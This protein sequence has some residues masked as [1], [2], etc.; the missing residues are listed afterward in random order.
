MEQLLSSLLSISE[1]SKL[2]WPSTMRN[3]N[4][5]AA[6]QGVEK[7]A[8]EIGKELEKQFSAFDAKTIS[9]EQGPGDPDIVNFKQLGEQVG[10]QVWEK[11]TQTNCREK[12]LRVQG[13]IAQVQA[14]VSAMDMNRFGIEPLYP[15][16]LLEELQ[17]KYE[18]DFVG[19]CDP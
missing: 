4:Q 19:V 12:Q 1:T 16:H 11:S 15:Q 8:Q 13:S 10:V 9:A 2:D 17:R 5:K 18:R 7:K 3:F 14:F 6:L